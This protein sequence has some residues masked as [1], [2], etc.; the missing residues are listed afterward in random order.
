MFEYR[1]FMFW[2]VKS[3]ARD[4]IPHCVGPLVGW[5]FGW[6]VGRSVTHLFFQRFSGSF[7]ITAPPNR[8]RLILPC[9]RPCFLTWSLTILF[10]N[11]LYRKRFH[12]SPTCFYN[13]KC[14]KAAICSL[15]IPI[16]AEECKELLSITILA[17]FDTLSSHENGI[18]T[19]MTILPIY[20]TSLRSM[21]AT[22]GSPLRLNNAYENT[23]THSQVYTVIDKKT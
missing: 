19:N 13:C 9:I 18:F 12:S 16:L 11:S 8:T 2:A 14:G 15:V 20:G 3:R 10:A 5:S 1:F 7:R 21:W 22:V 4:S 6:S 17:N 23:K